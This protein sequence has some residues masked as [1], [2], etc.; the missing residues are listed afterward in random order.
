[1]NEGA[2]WKNKC[3]K[4]RYA[5]DIQMQGEPFAVSWSCA[6]LNEPMNRVKICS[7]GPYVFKQETDRVKIIKRVDIVQLEIELSREFGVS[8][9]ACN[10]IFA[11]IK[12]LRVIQERLQPILD[13]HLMQDP[14]DG[15]C[16]EGSLWSDFRRVRAA[17]EAYKGMIE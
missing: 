2:Y 12:L 10:A 5:V 16:E 1:M 3:E 4:C 6:L 17:N 15:Y 8:W 13:H 9:S 11:E 7:F 14:G